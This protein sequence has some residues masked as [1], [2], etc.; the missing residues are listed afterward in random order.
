M[1]KKFFKVLL[2][3]LIVPVFF[4]VSNIINIYADSTEGEETK[5]YEYEET[6]DYD[7][8]TVGREYLTKDLIPSFNKTFSAPYGYDF[9][10]SYTEEQLEALMDEIDSVNSKYTYGGVIYS[11]NLEGSTISAGSDWHFS[12]DD[13][14]DSLKQFYRDKL[15]GYSIF[16]VDEL[17]VAINLQFKVE[18]CLANKDNDGLDYTFILKSDSFL[19]EP[20]DEYDF[21]NIEA[22]YIQNDDREKRISIS[23]DIIDGFFYEV[24]YGNEGNIS[25]FHTDTTHNNYVDESGTEYFLADYECAFYLHD[26][27]PLSGIRS[28][29]NGLE[30]TYPIEH[31]PFP[32]RAKVTFMSGGKEYT[33]WSREVVVGNPDVHIVID[34]HESRDTV[35]IGTEHEYLLEYEDYCFNHY[36]EGFISA[37]LYPYFLNDSEYI[38]KLFDNPQLPEKGIEGHLYYIPTDEEIERYKNGEEI[39]PDGREYGNYYSW[40]KESNAFDYYEGIDI[41]NE[42]LDFTLKA[43]SIASIPYTGLWNIIINFQFFPPMSNIDLTNQIIKVIDPP[44]TKDYIEL[45]VSDNINLIQ[46]AGKI[47]IESKIITESDIQTDYYYKYLTGTDGIIEVT[48]LED[49]KF[50][51]NPIGVGVTELTIEVESD[52]FS[53]I[54]KTI[55]IRVLDSV[56]DIAKIEIPNE[57][58]YAGKD[59]DVKLNIRGYTNFLNLNIEWIILDKNDNPLDSTKYV[60]NKD[61]TISLTKAERNDYTIKALYNGIELD[62]I[63]V[64]VRK[65][66]INKVIRENIWWIFLITIAFVFVILFLKNMLKR[67]KTTVESIERVYSVY[68]DCL[69]DDKLTLAE[70]KKIN[71]E[72]KKCLHRCEDLNI[73]ALNQY[74][75]SI[76]YLRK[77]SNDAKSLLNEWENITPEDKSVYC[78]RLNADLSKAL[79]VAIELENA[80]Q[81]SEEYHHNANRKNF[82]TIEEDK[83]KK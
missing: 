23:A 81:I 42:Y 47:E 15:N 6:P 40:N 25:G 18:I 46:N 30:I 44:T 73:E 59:L 80:K 13:S 21:V 51:V 57:F 63:E 50:V 48:E 14:R 54:T 11:Y 27:I 43:K 1:I 58:H 83:S 37:Y 9:R 76:R 4:G 67:G 41:M 10:L 60:D 66:N 78:E 24:G 65:I 3:L 17:N 36:Y 61:A 22:F 56:Y 53:K 68:C 71:K 72:I 79:N 29:E 62:T 35:V 39:Y 49:G 70:L 75:K 7:Y 64:Q 28:S 69:S 33:Y 82:E 19:M 34:G 32:I 26:T 38:H 5:E 20:Y 55:I 12:I 52:L 2:F 31:E 45:N 77:S 16:K 8:N 74:E